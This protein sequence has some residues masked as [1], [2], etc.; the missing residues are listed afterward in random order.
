MFF[1]PETGNLPSGTDNDV[2]SN[3]PLWAVNV[4][5][6]IDNVVASN[7]PLWMVNLFSGIDHAVASQLPL[8]AHVAASHLPVAHTLP[9]PPPTQPT[10]ALVAW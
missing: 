7:L 2:A 4:F 8:W 3:L 1:F 10:P 5:S 9:L 6:G